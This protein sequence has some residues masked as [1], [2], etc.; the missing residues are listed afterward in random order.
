MDK[1][2][3]LIKGA[4]ELFL[5]VGV[6]SIN[7]DD[8]S[9][10]LGISKKTLYKIVSNKADLVKQTFTL[11]QECFI[12]MIEGI[13][14]KNSNPIDEIFEIDQHLSILL[15]NRP[16]QIISNLKKHYPEVWEILDSIR[17]ENIIECVT[18]N[19]ESGIAQGLYR[20]NL[21]RNILAKLLINTLEAIVDDTLF[22][23]TEYDFKT[24]LQE[25]REYHIRGI[26]TPKGITYLEN[27]LQND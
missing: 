24:I 27:K 9:T 8:V 18:H 20:S 5:K 12:Q 13:K 6:K 22:P 11:H 16:P 4:L 14:S 19:I 21:N 10:H 26:A 15:K 17:R 3:Q 7:M 1:K 25:N 23:F 2:E